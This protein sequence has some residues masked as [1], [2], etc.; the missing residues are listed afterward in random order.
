VAM[1]SAEEAQINPI[2]I[3]TP[4]INCYG[5]APIQIQGT[6]MTASAAQLNAAGGGTTATITPTTAT[7]GTLLTIS[8]TLVLTPETVTLTKGNFTLT[9][10]NGIYWLSGHSGV[11]TMSLAAGQCVEIWNMVGTN[12]VFDNGGNQ[13]VK[14]STGTSATNGLMDMISF[15]AN[16]NWMCSG[17]RDN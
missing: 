12:V 4:Q 17:I 2:R 10:T 16:T 6:N 13:T 9:P 8:K 1:V 14:T 5:S 3:S 7:V 15:T 11:V